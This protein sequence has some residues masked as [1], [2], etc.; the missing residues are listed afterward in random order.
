[1]LIAALTA[2]AIVTANLPYEPPATARSFIP[3]TPAAPAT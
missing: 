3:S 2:L 1:V